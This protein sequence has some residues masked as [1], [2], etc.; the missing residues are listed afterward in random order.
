MKVSVLSVAVVDDGIRGTQK[1]V[2]LSGT[3]RS[4]T[5]HVYL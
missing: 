2:P 3:Y 5:D 4:V 1:V